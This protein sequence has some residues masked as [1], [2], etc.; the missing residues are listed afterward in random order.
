M[1]AARRAVD[2]VAYA[3]AWTSLC[4][5]R[6]YAAVERGAPWE[7]VNPATGR[8]EL[9]DNICG[10]CF[11]PLNEIVY[12][13]TGGTGNCSHTHP[14]CYPRPDLGQLHDGPHSVQMDPTYLWHCHC[15]QPHYH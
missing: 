7:Y 1:D 8:V 13:N 9:P 3:D 15:P 11:K 14:E 5:A 10:L 2:R 12:C 4:D 6:I